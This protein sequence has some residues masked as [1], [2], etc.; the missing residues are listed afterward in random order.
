MKKSQELGQYFTTN[1]DLK[2]KVLEFV[3][4]KP[5]VILE[6]SV[7]Q[8]DLIEIIYNSD[9]NIQFDMYEIDTKIK[10]LDNIPKNVI[11]GDFIKK[12]M[13]IALM[14]D[15]RVSEGEKINFF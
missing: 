13:S 5:N 10:M 7:G 4:N 15:Q 12:D 2:N 11:Y 9:N 6:P 8:G 1:Y 3:M 14:I